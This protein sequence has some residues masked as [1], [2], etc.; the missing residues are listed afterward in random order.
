[1]FLHGLGSSS[2]HDFPE[3]A[4]HPAL[5]ATDHRSLLVDLLGFGYSD[6]PTDFTY[7]LEAHAATVAAV[8]DA[9]GVTGAE[10]VGH[11]MGGSVALALAASR[12]GLVGSLTLA[13]ANLRAGGGEWSGKIAEWREEEFLSRG[14]GEFA[15]AETDPGY[16][17]TL[18]LAAPYALH[19]SAV[20]LVHG[21]SPQLA[22][23]LAAFE[24]P[25]AF[26]VGE[27]SRPYGEEEDAVGA[28]AQVLTVPRSGHVMP[29]DNPAGLAEALA[30]ASV[31]AHRMRDARN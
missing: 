5:A 13:E 12:P 30:E 22:A 23:V 17:T 2:T 21:T 31:L 28:G 24:G 10:I 3:I 27:L 19:R 7:S 8:L 6:R 9:E 18:R 20:G 4:T 29:L 11:S 14:Y 26:L 25:K 15:A 1:M 16:L